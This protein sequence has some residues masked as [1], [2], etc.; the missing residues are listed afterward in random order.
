[1]SKLAACVPGGALATL[2]RTV[3]PARNN[4]LRKCSEGKI[5]CPRPLGQTTIS[6]GLVDRA[7][8]GRQ[9]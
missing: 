2:E 1:M 5:A 7:H 6:N 3:S 9:Q 8:L 4:A